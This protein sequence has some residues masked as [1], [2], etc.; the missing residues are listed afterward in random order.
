MNVKRLSDALMLKNTSNLNMNRQIN[1]TVI[2]NRNIFDIKSVKNNNFVENGRKYCV[3]CKIFRPRRSSHCTYCDCCVEVF[4][5][6]CKFVNN[7]I[8]KYNYKYFFAFL[9]LLQFTFLFQLITQIIYLFKTKTTSLIN[10][11]NYGVNFKFN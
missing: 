5:H 9:S 2:H 7:C 1:E 4:D 3:T 10:C 11:K 6:H 8:G